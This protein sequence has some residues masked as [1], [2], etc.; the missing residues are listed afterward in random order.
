MLQLQ[1]QQLSSRNTN[2][3]FVEVGAAAA[4]QA[5][6]QALGC[7]LTDRLDVIQATFQLLNV[8]TQHRRA[9]RPAIA[10]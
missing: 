7:V 4:G 10:T 1:Q 8:V 2:Q 3:S 9:D 6:E 5:G